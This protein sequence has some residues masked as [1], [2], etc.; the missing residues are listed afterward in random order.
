[1]QWLRVCSLEQALFFYAGPA[2]GYL[3]REGVLL[4]DALPGLFV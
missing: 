4:V 2:F 3:G 1:M